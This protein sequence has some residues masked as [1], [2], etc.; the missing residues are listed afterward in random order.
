M[1]L[2]CGDYIVRVGKG[3][4]HVE[5]L[6]NDRIVCSLPDEEP[7]SVVGDSEGILRVEVGMTCSKEIILIAVYG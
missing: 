3:R 1:G 7:Q 4:C 6:T 2:S 5:G